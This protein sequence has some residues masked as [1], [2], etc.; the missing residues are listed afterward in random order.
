MIGLLCARGVDQVVL[1]PVLDDLGFG[2]EHLAAQLVDAACESH[3]VARCAASYFAS[4]WVTRYSS[5]ILLA[6]SAALAGSSDRN[7]SEIT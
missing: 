2:L 6:I 3:S 4:T 7:D 5:A 1:G